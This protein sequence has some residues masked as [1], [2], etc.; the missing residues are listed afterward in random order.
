MFEDRGHPQLAAELGVDQGDQA[1]GEER[2]PAEGEEVVVDAEVRGV[3]Q[4]PPQAQQPFLVGVRGRARGAV[5]AG[6]RGRGG[7]GSAL[8]SSLPLAVS[9]MAS[10][11]TQA[12]GTM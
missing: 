7:S 9:G 12:V 11:R 10:I 2:V 4:P 5:R 6:G 1:H 3:E 8:R